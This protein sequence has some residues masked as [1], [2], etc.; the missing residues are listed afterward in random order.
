LCN[1]KG[2]THTGDLGSQYLPGDP[3]TS[4]Q[5]W[6]PHELILKRG[7]KKGP[8]GAQ[9]RGE[10]TPGNPGGATAVGKTPKLKGITPKAPKKPPLRWELP[11]KYLL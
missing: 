10:W 5:K 1:K 6:N 11:P 2:P 3:P 4:P 8:K 9:K 7:P